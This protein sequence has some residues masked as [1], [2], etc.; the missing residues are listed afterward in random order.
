[1]LGAKNAA[2]GLTIPL[3]LVTGCS[4]MDNSASVA[5]VRIPTELKEIFEFIAEERG[6]IYGE[7]SKRYAG[8]PNVGKVYEEFLNGRIKIDYSNV[9]DRDKWEKSV[10]RDFDK[11][12]PGHREDIILPAF[13]GNNLGARASLASFIKEHHD[14]WEALSPQ[15]R[16]LITTWE[17]KESPNQEL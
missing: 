16:W 1:M 6:L 12:F 11:A 17:I 8:L 14:Y 5:V 3:K 13:K 15:D 7:K 2:I 10:I 4:I 9:D